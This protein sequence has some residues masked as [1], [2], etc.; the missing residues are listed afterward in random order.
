MKEMPI[1]E[2]LQFAAS[3]Y[4]VP[5][6]RSLRDPITFEDVLEALSEDRLND[7]NISGPCDARTSLWSMASH[8]E[9]IAWFV[10]NGWEEPIT[11]DMRKLWPIVDGNHRFAAAI[12]RQD[13]HVRVEFIGE[14]DTPM[15][16]TLG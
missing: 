3:P 10:E 6:W 11:V 7:P 15:S 14:T 2:L 16:A 5:L 12:Y 4:E 8:A 13:T 1:A 9:R